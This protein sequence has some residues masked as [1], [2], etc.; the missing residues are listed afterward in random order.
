[1]AIKGRASQL[2]SITG[3]VV[4]ATLLDKGDGL[5]GQYFIT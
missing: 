3:L 1:M 2:L 5:V 4:F